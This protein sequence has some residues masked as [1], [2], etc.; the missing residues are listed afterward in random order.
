LLLA[1]LAGNNP[2]QAL[3]GALL[4]AA[5]LPVYFIFFRKRNPGGD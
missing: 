3:L 1:L 2:R 4:T 5:G